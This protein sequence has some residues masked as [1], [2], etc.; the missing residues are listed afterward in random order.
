VPPNRAKSL[1]LKVLGDNIRRERVH[2]GMTQERLAEMVA[3]HP[4][5]VQKIEAGKVD[6]LY[7][8]FLRI[9]RGLRCSWDNLLGKS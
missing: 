6:I 4:R 5:T 3:L 9:Q 2:R 8:T 1:Q 7:T